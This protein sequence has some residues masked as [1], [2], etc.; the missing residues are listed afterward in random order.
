VFKNAKAVLFLAA[1][2]PILC[3]PLAGFTEATNEPVVHQFLDL[4]F[5]TATPDDAE[6]A[7]LAKYDVGWDPAYEHYRLDGVMEF[8]HEFSMGM[9][10]NLNQVGITRIFMSPAH[11]NAWS[12][13]TEVFKG[14]LRRDIADFILL[15]SLITEQYGQ[16]DLRFFRTDGA[17]YGVKGIVKAMFSDGL[18]DAEQMMEICRADNGTMAFAVWGNVVLEYW[19]I[20]RDPGLKK[21]QS[22][23][24]LYYYDTVNDL[25]AS[26]VVDYPPAAN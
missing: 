1:A 16:P 12:G 23:I 2:L 4:S 24:T 9:E 6:Q 13:E 15:D 5:D 7:M 26:D 21:S 11:T 18:W 14:M 3:L 10:F 17:K 20:W 19:A 22:Y 25:G 8:D